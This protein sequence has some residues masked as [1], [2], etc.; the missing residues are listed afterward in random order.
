MDHSLRRCSATRTLVMQ[1][2][3][4]QCMDTK[5]GGGGCTMCYYTREKIDPLTD[6][7]GFLQTEIAIITYSGSF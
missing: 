4:I 2:E 7:S 3:F 1:I 6:R 5:I